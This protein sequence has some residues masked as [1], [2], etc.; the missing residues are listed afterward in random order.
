MTAIWPR[1]LP[2]LPLAAEIPW[3]VHRYRVGKASA[4]RMNV[5]VLGP[6]FWIGKFSLSCMLGKR[7][8]GKKA[9]RC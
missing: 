9:H 4:G 6:G 2:S 5:V 3:Q 7:N 8:K 1:T